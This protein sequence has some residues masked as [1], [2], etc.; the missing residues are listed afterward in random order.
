MDFLIAPHEVSELPFIFD[1]WSRSFRKSPWA[2]C[3]P[4]Y[5]W[6]QVVR[7]CA[8]E[9]LDRGAE[10][11]VALAP[12]TEARRVMGYSVAEPGCLHWLYVKTDYRRL[13]I[14]RKLLDAAV[15]RWPA[16]A[17]RTYSHRTRASAG[18]LGP[19]WRWDPVPAR[20]KMDRDGGD[21]S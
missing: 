14:G 20:V 18:F 4:N 19:S 1:S 9:I 17:P 12:G 16:D 3:V 2:G 6:E 11:L 15:Q 21:R 5:L 13:S 7:A 8:T 10:V